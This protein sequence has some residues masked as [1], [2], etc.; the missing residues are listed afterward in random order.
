M[1]YVGRII[2]LPPPS[3]STFRQPLPRGSDIEVAPPRLTPPTV[4]TVIESILPSPLTKQHV[5]K[6]LQHP[7]GLVQYLTALTLARGLQKLDLVQ[8]LFRDIESEMGSQPS[9]STTSGESPWAA[10]GRELEMECRRRVPDLQVL[11]GFAQ[12]SATLAPAEPETDE[13]H[14]LVAKS[15]MITEVALRL[16]G[17]YHRTL[18]SLAQE[19]RFDVGRLLV[20]SSSNKAERR[21]RQQAKADKAGSVIGVETG[22]VASVG[23]AGTAGMGGGFG[24]ARGDV[25]GF[26]A[27]SQVHVVELLSQAKGWQWTNKAGKWWTPQTSHLTPHTSHLTPHTPLPAPGLPLL[28]VRHVGV[29]LSDRR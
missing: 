23:T 11:I 12:K 7:D 18:P 4:E 13:D 28:T 19:V 3:M 26:E 21:E 6:G 5:T 10:R 17:L 8:R 16:F 20:S 15:A 25:K 1:A 9:T 14:A 2:S 27:L 24:Y 29:S 22:S